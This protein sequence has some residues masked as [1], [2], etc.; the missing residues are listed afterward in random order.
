[1]LKSFNNQVLRSLK[2][3]PQSLFV[4]ILAGL[5]ILYLLLSYVAI[6][7]L[8][9]KIVPSIAE[10]ALDSKASVGHVKFD[11]FRLKATINDFELTE[12][13]GAPLA[14]FKTL[15]ID[16][17]LSGMFDLA[18]KLK[19][20]SVLSPKV[21]LAV[22]S[23]GELNWADLLRKLNQD[24]TPPSDTIPRLII[25]H[26]RVDQGELYYAD[27]HRSEPIS[28]TL[29]PLNF[30]LNGFSTLPKD[31]GDYFIS[32]TFA[33]D[34]GTLKWKGDMGVNP[35]ASKGVVALESVKIASL[36]QLVKGLT[37]PIQL[38]S[39]DFQASFSYDF[40]TP[41]AIATLGLNNLMLGLNNVDATLPQGTTLSLTYVGLGAEQLDFVNKQQPESHVKG[42]DFKLTGLNVQQANESQLL[43]EEVAA[44][45]PQL[46]FLMADS[47]QL[48]FEHL[49]ATLTNTHLRPSP[50][51]SLALPTVSVNEV[52]LD[53]DKQK[54]NIKEVILSKVS[55]GQASSD[56]TN[57][58]AANKPLATLEQVLLSDSLI[59]LDNQAISAQSL[60]FS[61][62]KSSV[63][64]NADQT[65][66]WVEIFKDQH[67]STKE[68]AS[69]APVK[70]VPSKT[71]PSQTETNKAPA[72]QL[73]LKKI[74]LNN[75][76]IHMQ[77]NSASI[78]VVMDVINTNIEVQ[79]ATLD[80]TKP[81]PVKVDFKVKQG[82]QFSTE[83]QLWPSPLKADLRVR[84]TGFS[85]KPFATYVN[86]FAL[87]KLDSGA[88]D[89]SGK[90]AMTQKQD[91]A[92]DFKGLFDVKQL[93]LLEEADNAPFLSWDHVRSKDLSVSLMP[94]KLHMATL[95]VVKPS[96]K[97]IIYPDNTIN[98]KRILRS[99]TSQEQEAKSV[100]VVKKMPKTPIV[101]N[102]SLI[103]SPTSHQSIESNKSN[104]NKVDHQTKLKPSATKA[105]DKASEAFPINIDSVRIDDGKLAFADLSLT[106]QFGTNIHSLNGVIN[107][108]STKI[109][110]VAQVELDGKVDD[111][112]S[113]RIRGA[114]QPFNATEFTDVKLVFTNVDMS[115]LTPYSGKFAGRRIEAGKLS[116]DL[117]YKI[118]Q[119]QLVGENK[120]VIN[121]LKLGEKVESSDAA[122]LPLDLAIA[123]LEDSDGVIDLDLPISGS[124]DDPTFSYGG[125]IWKAFKNVLTKI[126]TAPFR[127]LGKLFGGGAEE[128]DGIAFEAGSSEVAPPE[129]E[130][131]VKVSQALTKRKGLSLGIAPSYHQQ[132]DT[133][134]IK[135]AV[136]RKQIA[137]EMGVELK[138]GQ[139]A[140]PV[141]LTNEKS[142]DAIDTLYDKLTK[143]GFLKRMASKFEKPEEGHYEKAQESLIASI[144]VTDNDL[145]QL[146][147]ARGQAIEAV[148]LS[149]GVSADRLSIIKVVE[150]KTADNQVKTELKLDVNKSG[151][152]SNEQNAENFSPE[153]M[154]NNQVSN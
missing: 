142:Q 53:L 26:I 9:K 147:V 12:K 128:F 61:G 141:D 103:Q 75:A 5:F 100:G 135:V 149:N 30:Q 54:I 106:P 76:E 151:A 29:T 93:A 22:D 118:K 108:L 92:I 45:L 70:T 96:G 8:A 49:N 18:W 48:V 21:S 102:N 32:A 134:A 137:E 132:L 120:V 64:K 138:D 16:L 74:A 58:L 140:G 59:A 37:L 47:P 81:L 44:Q 72:W 83:G 77:D 79:D 15:I 87:L 127:A 85:L 115:R 125:I 98:V 6:N 136:Y 20:I 143:K 88:L 153:I 41:Q 56:M 36:L 123:I 69:V 126:V 84:L 25:E 99:E 62:F 114:L 27:A 51:L 121:K 24:K 110:K 31:R 89:V 80:M 3:L 68:N 150:V 19:Q 4:K 109:E 73:A 116:V 40:S 122:D 101:S 105:A 133:D 94:N 86:Q 152:E 145:K 90:L 71:V 50:Q 2:K 46:D 130:K 113:A 91:L 124:L 60:S 117:A 33:D 55:F 146:A 39:G 148:L 17:E 66:N 14:S 111:Y 52:G 38:N 119:H 28:T 104:K 7:P 1:M 129:L 78:P 42:L 11:P 43:L 107:G 112:G 67:G 63:V 82:G 57:K 13:N 131:L 97:F 65:L 144:E 154:P 95:E 139:R 34:G 10:S 35:I 23:D